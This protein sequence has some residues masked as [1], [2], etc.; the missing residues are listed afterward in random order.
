MRILRFCYGVA[1]DAFNRFHTDDGWAIASHIALSALMSL[2][3]FLIVV[4]ALAGFIGSKE[5]ADEAARILLEAWPTT[6]AEPI[7]REIHS[8]L[9][10]AR[11]GVLTIGVALAIYFASS[12]IESLRI[13]LNRA[14]GL[15]EPRHWWLLRLESIGYVL[16][17]AVSLLALAFLIVLAPLIFATTVRHAPWLSPLWPVLNFVRFAVTAVVLVTALFIA[18]KWLPSG[19]RRLGEI[20][21]GMIATMVLWLVAGEVFGRYLADFAYTYV[22][23]YAGLASAMIAL[24]FL[25]LIA[26]IFIYGAELNTAV[27]QARKPHKHG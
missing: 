16:V 11:G 6:V 22:S 13:G 9:T 4:T 23:Y 5:L 15:S 8:V 18:H 26:S 7:S 10:T 27:T 1:I 2:F 21:P 12:G 20:A 14:Y 19:R 3:P 24:V 25:Y 17:A